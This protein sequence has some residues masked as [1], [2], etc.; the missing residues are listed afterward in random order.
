LK[1]NYYLGSIALLIAAVGLI[2]TRIL[3]GL[4]IFDNI[5]VA[6]S[7][8]LGSFIIQII[9]IGGGGLIVL[10]VQHF[11]ARK[12]NNLLPL[13]DSSNKITFKTR[14]KEM[15]FRLPR[16]YLIPLS[17]VLGIL[18]FI[19]TIGVS[20]INQLILLLLGYNVPTYADEAMGGVGLF[21]LAL[22]NTAILPGICEEF[23]NRGLILR[24]LRDTMQDKYAII[25]SALIFGLLHANVR[26]TLY[27]LVGG[28]IF[29]TLTVKTRSIL[30]A[31]I[32]HFVNNGISVYSS[33]AYYNGWIG[34][35]LDS[36]L[37][38]H[39]GLSVVLWLVFTAVLI[40]LLI[41]IVKAETK[42]Q[43]K[44]QLQNP[45][46]SDDVM[47][48]THINSPFG[49]VFTRST[50][51]YRPQLEDKIVMYISVFLLAVTTVFSFYM[52]L[53]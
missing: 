45:V 12:K 4:G 41:L 19:M 43:K 21:L 14:L 48:T 7:D 10:T 50:P 8:F 52:G 51:L 39:F 9:F 31:M 32:V 25:I 47:N 23:L 5:P 17:F 20:Y 13:Q 38:D 46:Q 16:I 26:Q 33:H 27:T 3:F 29:A 53:F 49:V 22:F 18:F 44:M 6:V 37:L 15:G 40:A 11:L 30:P 42:H 1:K 28:V 24:G 35:D 36:F 2:I 34:G